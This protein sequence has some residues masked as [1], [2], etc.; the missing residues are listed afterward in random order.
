MFFE[1][2]L[3]RVSYVIYTVRADNPAEAEAMAFAACERDAPGEEE[4]YSI[5][6]I[7]DVGEPECD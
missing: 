7:E 3:K 6:S 4:F 2:E 5:E 1:V